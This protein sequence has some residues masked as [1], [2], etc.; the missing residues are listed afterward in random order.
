MFVLPAK[1]LFMALGR[2]PLRSAQRCVNGVN[3][4]PNNRIFCGWVQVINGKLVRT[5]LY[6]NRFSLYL[7]PG[8]WSGFQLVYTPVSK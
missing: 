8:T 5:Q 1:W 6:T 7:A 4:S 2:S 3:W